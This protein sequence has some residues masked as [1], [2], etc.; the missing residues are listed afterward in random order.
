MFQCLIQNFYF[1]IYK[2]NLIN[3]KLIT[4]FELYLEIF[5]ICR[6]STKN[7]HLNT[8]KYTA[9]SYSHVV[10]GLIV[11]EYTLATLTFESYID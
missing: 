7:R 1:F 5:D 8:L 9:T 2:N 3:N 6:I 11:E 10:A 4:R